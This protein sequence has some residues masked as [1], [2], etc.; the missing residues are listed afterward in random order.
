MPTLPGEDQLVDFALYQRRPGCAFAREH[1]ANIVGNSGLGEQ[2][3]QF[4]RDQRRQL[5]GLE[6]HSISR[7]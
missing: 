7:H 4:E 5:G 2:R 6:H 1:L 3:L